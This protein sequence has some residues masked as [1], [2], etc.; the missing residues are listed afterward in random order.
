[1]RVLVRNFSSVC[2]PPWREDSLLHWQLWSIRQMGTAVMTPW[3]L[4][5]HWQR[6]WQSWKSVHR[7]WGQ[8]TQSWENINLHLHKNSPANAGDARHSVRSLGQED[9]SEENGNPLQYS[10]LENS[11]D[12]GALQATVH[13]VAKSQT[14]LK[15]LS[16]YE[17]QYLYWHTTLKW[18]INVFLLERNLRQTYNCDF[19]NLQLRFPVI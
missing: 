11:L 6:Y 16:M 3:L 4:S 7:C 1:M 14:Q 8:R 15:Q 9:L 13:R 19:V 12:R 17:Y 10:C 2:L 18:I 5:H